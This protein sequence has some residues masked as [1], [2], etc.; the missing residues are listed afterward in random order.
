MLSGDSCM[1]LGK[2][3]RGGKAIRTR[4]EPPNNILLEMIFGAF[5]LVLVIIF[6]YWLY[7]VSRADEEE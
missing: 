5:V 1:V 4:M 6:F 7:R 3:H 2:D